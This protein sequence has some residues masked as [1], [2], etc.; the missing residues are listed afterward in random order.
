M[1][2]PQSFVRT[3]DAYIP[4][5]EVD[6]SRNKIKRAALVRVIV[7]LEDLGPLEYLRQHEREVKLKYKDELDEIATIPASINVREIP[8]SNVN[9]VEKVYHFQKRLVLIC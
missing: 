7:Y 5:D 4:I 9:D 2:T 3:Y 8:G 1:Q 6:E